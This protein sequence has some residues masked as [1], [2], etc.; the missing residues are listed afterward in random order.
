M[1]LLFDALLHKYYDKSVED[2]HKGAV[3]H[4]FAEVGLPLV[5]SHNTPNNSV[6]LLWEKKTD[7]LFPRFERHQGRQKEE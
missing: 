2:E 1:D 6:Y 5:L 4:G 7:P 3:V